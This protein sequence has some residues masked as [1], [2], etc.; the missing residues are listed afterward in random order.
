[1]NPN[2]TI[3]SDANCQEEKKLRKDA[4]VTTWLKANLST[5]THMD[6]FFGGKISHLCELKN[7]KTLPIK[8]LATLIFSKK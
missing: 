6:F 5:K 2:I 3:F 7:V 1:M 8:E 4:Q